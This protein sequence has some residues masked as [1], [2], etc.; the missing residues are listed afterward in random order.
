MRYIVT[1]TVTHTKEFDV[2]A[3]EY[4]ESVLSGVNGCDIIMVETVEE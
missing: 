1:Y 2:P 3:Y 4:I